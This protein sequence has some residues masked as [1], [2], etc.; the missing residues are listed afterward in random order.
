[1]QQKFQKRDCKM[2]AYDKNQRIWIYEV[3]D[4]ETGAPIYVGRTNDLLKRGGQHERKSSACKMLRA[5]LSLVDWLLRDAMRIVPELPN[6]VPASRACEFEAYF[7]IQRKTLFHP[8][9]Q[10]HGCNLRHG[11]HVSTINID[12]IKEEVERGFEWPEVVTPEVVVT[13]KAVQAAL[14]DLT[15]IAGDIE[16]EL[17][18]ALTV[19]TKR[20]HQEERRLVP[21]VHVAESLA[22]S[23][24]IGSKIAEVDR[25]LFVRDLNRIRDM[26]HDQDEPD[27]KMLQLLRSEVCFAKPDGEKWTMSREVAALK[28]KSLAKTLAMR[29]EEKM[30]K[31]ETTLKLMRARD[32]VFHNGMARPSVRKKRPL[33]AVV[34]EEEDAA[35]ILR[36]WKM[37]TG[38]TLKMESRQEADFLFRDVDWWRDFVVSEAT[39]TLPVIV[40][41]AKRNIFDKVVGA[42]RLFRQDIYRRHLIEES[43]FANG[44]ILGPVVEGYELLVRKRSVE[45]FHVD[46]YIK[47][48]RGTILRSVPDLYRSLA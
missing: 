43:L 37:G 35:I 3:V 36:D 20:L 10:V 8:P 32:W 17:S 42:L 4:Q 9:E 19:A 47:P 44:Q 31:T 39:R 23:Y 6:G 48:P 29:H 5:R 16:P 33:S 45:S 11:D 24:E 2:M 25:V 46:F 1:M 12:A 28:L 38:T 26:I 30:Q 15:D 34:K 18:T 41:E 27:S 40:D 21:L 14:S 13:C 22:S 7:I